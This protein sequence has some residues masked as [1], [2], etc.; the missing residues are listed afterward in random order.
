MSVT[1]S[2]RRNGCR[3]FVLMTTA[4]SM[5]GLLAVVGLAIDV[6]HLY[7]ARSE[8]Q[9]FV[10]ESRLPPVSNWTEPRRESPAPK[11][12][13]RPA[14]FPALRST[15]GTLA[16]K[17]PLRRRSSS[18]ALP[19]A[20]SSPVRRTPPAIASFIYLS[21]PLQIG[22][23]VPFVPGQKSVASAIDERFGEDTDT[24]HA[25]FSTYTGDGRRLLVVP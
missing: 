12:W 7:V 14:R 5:V 25:T 15:A 22:S 19:A 8:L 21:Q 6:G 3:G 10:D 9:I 18:P 2:I 20:R 17:L 4:S 24:T 13:P 1:L 23:P 11:P 16:R